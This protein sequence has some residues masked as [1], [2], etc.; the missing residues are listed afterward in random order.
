[1]SD[2]SNEATPTDPIFEHAAV[3]QL[4]SIEHVSPDVLPPSTVEIPANP[5]VKGLVA[6]VADL[7]ARINVTLGALAQSRLQHGMLYVPAGDGTD[8]ADDG[9]EVV[10]MPADEFDA[11]IERLDALEESV[12]KLSDATPLAGVT[13]DESGKLFVVTPDQ[14]SHGPY[15]TIGDAHREAARL[16]GQVRRIA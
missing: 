10:E 7:E 8:E 16:G 13:V 14:E 9:L 6:Y 2:L 3:E 15:A 12:R 11:L 1:M 4:E 5:T